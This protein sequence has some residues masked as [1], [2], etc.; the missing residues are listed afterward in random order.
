MSMYHLHRKA[1]HKGVPDQAYFFPLLP[2]AGGGLLS[3]FPSALLGPFC[4]PRALLSLWIFFSLYNPSHLFSPSSRNGKAKKISIRPLQLSLSMP[5][6]LSFSPSLLNLALGRCFRYLISGMIRKSDA[7]FIHRLRISLQKPIF[8]TC[9]LHLILHLKPF[10]RGF[11]SYMADCE[12]LFS[13]EELP[14]YLILEILTSGRLSSVDLACLEKTSRIF[15]STLGLVPHTFRS[16]AEFAAVQLCEAHLIF[17][18]L[19]GN[20]RTELLDRCGGNWKKVLRFLQSVEQASGMVE[21]SAGN[22]LLL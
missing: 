6:L 1:V 10:S 20:A 9:S 14:S 3:T 18:A 7:F 5:F 15:T 4:P 12:R 16:L 2:T 17:A 22:V 21:T 19:P 13:I 8:P 11:F